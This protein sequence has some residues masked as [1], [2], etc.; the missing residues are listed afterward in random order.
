[1]TGTKMSMAPIDPIILG[2]EGTAHTL[3]VGIVQGANILADEREQYVPPSGGIH[4]R[5][6]AIHM[7]KSLNRVL[8]RAFTKTEI[9]PNDLDAVAFSIG[10]GLGA[11]LRTVATA[12]RALALLLECPLIGTNHCIAHVEL[13][14]L[15][16]GAKDPLTLYVSG[17]NT[18]I[19]TYD[20][21]RYRVI[22]E[23]LDIAVGNA[24]DTFAREV[25]LSHPGGPLVEKLAK[26]SALK[27]PMGLPYTVKGMSL[28]FSGLVTAAIRLAT[29]PGRSYSLEDTCYAFQEVAF[30]MLAE[31]T[32]RALVCTKKKE[33]VLT[34]GVAANERLK[35][36]IRLVSQEHDQVKMLAVP[37]KLALDNGVMIAWMGVLMYRAGQTMA[38]RDSYVQPRQRVEEIPAVWV[39]S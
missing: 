23:T 33:I 15:L 9:R 25:G 31:V 11:C 1:M 28:S 14:K 26:K 18:Q 12:A 3:G 20:N 17:G 13:G 30:S 16:S 19:I 4:P 24:I 39:L 21:G 6:S 27:E 8:N 10:P 35:E 32:E 37:P 29:A 7:A 22:G 34:G 38:I 5:E 2:L 36:M